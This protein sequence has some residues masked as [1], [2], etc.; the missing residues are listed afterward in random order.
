[1]KSDAVNPM[2]NSGEILDLTKVS[3]RD[4]SNSFSTSDPVT[5]WCHDGK[6]YSSKGEEYFGCLKSSCV[7]KPQSL[8]LD[9]IN[10][11]T[12]AY[13]SS[14]FLNVPADDN[15]VLKLGNHQTWRVHCR[16]KHEYKANYSGAWFLMTC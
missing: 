8:K 5:V 14:K 4:N 15:Q 6:F 10:F 2:I 11:T 9:M 16:N 13:D 3:C 12:K 7:V 1:M